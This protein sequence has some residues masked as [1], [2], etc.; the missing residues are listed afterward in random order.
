[1]R[2]LVSKILVYLFNERLIV[3]DQFDIS[4]FKFH[5]QL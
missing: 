3:D 1:M 4:S 2:D 5:Y